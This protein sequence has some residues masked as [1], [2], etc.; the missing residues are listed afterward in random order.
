LQAISGALVPAAK[1]AARLIRG[2]QI[3]RSEVKKRN[4][5]RIEYQM[6]DRWQLGGHF[7]S[8]TLGASLDLQI[9][10]RDRERGIDVAAPAQNSS[11]TRH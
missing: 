4:R 11:K 1:A 5:H 7:L 10:L 6:K 3:V 8:Q 2:D 9:C